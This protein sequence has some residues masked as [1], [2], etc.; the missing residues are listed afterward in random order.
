[1]ANET[2]ALRAIGPT[3]TETSG[4]GPYEIEPC[5]QCRRG[6]PP[7][8]LSARIAAG[9]DQTRVSKEHHSMTTASD[10]T[11]GVN[12]DPGHD[13]EIALRNTV[14]AEE[15]GLDH[16]LIQ[17]HAYNPQFVETW[18]LL[19]AL[20]GATERIALGP[21]V[22]TSPLHLPA[23]IAKSAATLDLIS[24]GRLVLGLGAG[25]W[26]EG[27]VG[28]GGP[29]LRERGTKFQAFQDTLRIVRGLW[30]SNGQ[31]FSYQG[32]V[33][34]VRNVQFGP[35]PARRIPIIT[36]SMGPQ[37]LRLTAKL[38]D[39]IS[40]STSYVPAERIP[41]FRAQLD[42]GARE[43]G[44]DPG[45]LR[46]YYNVMGFIETGNSTGNSRMRPRNPSVYWGDPVWW[47]ETLGRLVTEA[48]VGGF[49]FWPV[50]GDHAQ[51][52]RLFANEVV[53]GVRERVQSESGTR[54]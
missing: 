16:A 45:E 54:A 32:P 48:G 47:I 18:T 31:P 23:M 37:S 25:A 34:S 46:I 53:P 28:L 6:G 8:G 21:N 11:F 39:G 35:I 33:H 13:Y 9:D 20:A 19:S 1:M 29:D 24:N 43:E 3:R 22:M 30:E 50:A 27:I 51:Q 49:T 7:K 4:Y 17:D 10:I 5:D 15:L 36:G 44:R 14:R 40:V 52:F 41:S 38:G 42:A 2:M 26:D 12:I